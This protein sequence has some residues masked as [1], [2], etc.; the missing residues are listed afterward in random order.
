MHA[1]PGPI[2]YRSR[3][4]PAGKMQNRKLMKDH[5]NTVFYIMVASLFLAVLCF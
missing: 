4:F 5:L 2:L 3:L 1:F